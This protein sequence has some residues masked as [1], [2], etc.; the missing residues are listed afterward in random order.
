ML[1]ASIET[2]LNADFSGFC[3]ANGLQ[4]LL[5]VGTYQ[6][7]ESSQKRL[8]RLHIFDT[9]RHDASGRHGMTELQAIDQPGIFGLEWLHP[10][11]EDIKPCLALALAD[12]CL[13]LMSIPEGTTL[14]DCS[15]VQ[16]DPESMVLSVDSQRHAA[17]GRALAAT[18]ASCQA[19]LVQ[20]RASC[21][22][23][24]QS[25]MPLRCRAVA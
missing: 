24:N 5:A 15:R 10:E 22:P 4:H 7:D 19:A 25:S 17:A 20:A 16:I 3:P 18:T 2:P 13:Q 8:G 14:E 21:Q 23:S 6:L 12:G 1:Q 11:A 9:S